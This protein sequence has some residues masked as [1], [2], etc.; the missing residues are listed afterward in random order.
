MNLQQLRE[1][2]KNGI[3]YTSCDWRDGSYFKYIVMKT[4]DSSFANY[5]IFA[6]PELHFNIFV[7]DW[8]VKGK[9]FVAYNY[10]YYKP[11]KHLITETPESITM[12]YDVWQRIQLNQ[13]PII[14]TPDYVKCE[15]GITHFN[16]NK[17]LKSHIN[18]REHINFYRK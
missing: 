18:S 13:E 15:C 3:E 4:Y 5:G 9:E 8:F 11:N 7:C 10:Y 6:K 14:L 16:N 12:R 17:N 2:A 1:F